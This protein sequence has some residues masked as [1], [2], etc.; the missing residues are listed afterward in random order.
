MGFFHGPNKP[1]LYI[2]LGLFLL[3]YTQNLRVPSYLEVA[4]LR[5]KGVLRVHINEHA[6]GFLSSFKAGCI[7]PLSVPN[8][9]W[10]RVTGG[11]VITLT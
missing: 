9:I 10:E 5:I 11:W 3:P 7:I 2:I 8:A 6:C 1:H 4:K